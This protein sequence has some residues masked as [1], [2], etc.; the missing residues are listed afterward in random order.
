[1]NELPGFAVR[2]V[3]GV[4]ALLQA[5]GDALSARFRACAVRGEIASYARAGSGHCYFTLKDADRA[6]GALRCCLFRRAAALGDF[7]PADGQRA[8]DGE[9]QARA[10]HL[11]EQDRGDEE[12]GPLA[13]RRHGHS[14]GPHRCEGK[15]LCRG[16]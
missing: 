5:A 4:A 15:L 13:R 14:V 8:A 12:G 2:Q 11:D 9:E 16:R 6:D 1:M 10:G 3:S 7:A